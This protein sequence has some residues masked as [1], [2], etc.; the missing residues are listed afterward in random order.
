[1]LGINGSYNH[2][3]QMSRAERLFGKTLRLPSSFFTRSKANVSKVDDPLLL[4]NL[5]KF[6]D[7]RSA[8]PINTHKNYRKVTVDEKLFETP[9]VYVRVDRVK[10][11]LE[12]TYTGPHQVQQR[13]DKY[14]T[15]RT[16]RGPKNVSLN[17]L[18]PACEVDIMQNSQ[19]NLKDSSNSVI[20]DSNCSTGSASKELKS[21]HESFTK[22]TTTSPESPAPSVQSPIKSAGSESNKVRDQIRLSCSFTFT[23]WLLI[24]P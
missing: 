5:M 4:Q 14:F 2:D 18:K 11:G 13:F 21:Q 12:P 17:R 9:S 10:K 16:S 3:I 20:A 22:T 24:L 6:F 7:H 8:A 23:L 1:M 15:I 19:V